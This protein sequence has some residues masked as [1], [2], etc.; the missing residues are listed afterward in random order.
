M[1]RIFVAYF[2]IVLLAVPVYAAEPA[3]QG[4][5]A[6]VDLNSSFIDA[7]AAAIKLDLATGRP[8]I[9]LRNGQ[10]VLVH[11]STEITANVI[12]PEYNTFKVFAHIPVAI[13]LMLGPPGAG[14]LDA[15]RLQQLRSYHAKMRR[16]EKN[17]DQTN[18]KDTDLVRQKILLAASRQFLEN[19]IEQQRF[20]IEELYAFTRRMTPMI[21]A[22]I[23]GAAKS[24]LDAMHQQVMTWKKKMLPEQWKKLRV[25]VQGAVL[26]RNG[27]LAKQYFERLLHIENEGMRLVY[28][29]LYFPPTPML[30]L[31]A[32][33]LV[34][35]GIG[36]A[37]FDNPVRMFRDV[38]ADAAAVY[39]KK[40]KFD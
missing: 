5:T 13:Y 37:V 2:V 39:I 20:S 4:D 35:R 38:L 28:M 11:N 3:N 27:D 6:L 1:I 8:I 36:I 33:R 19:V 26:A 21:K 17:I 31:L 30:T 23:A 9:L 14:K 12:L 22:N 25:A 7:Y 32:T 15:E 16:A 18:L 10:L 24:Q 40:M 29:E 34:D